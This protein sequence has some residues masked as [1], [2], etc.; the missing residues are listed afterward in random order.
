MPPGSWSFSN[1]GSEQ[2]VPWAQCGGCDE[3]LWCAHGPSGGGLLDVV[4]WYEAASAVRPDRRA[5]GGIR[6]LN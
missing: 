3:W 2:D 4:F 5:I 1:A 6:D